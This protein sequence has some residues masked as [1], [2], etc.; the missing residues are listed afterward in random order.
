[1]PREHHYFT[2]IL[3]SGLRGTL[4]VGVT[5]DLM[6][7]VEEHR[8]GKGGAFTRRY[9]IH[10]LVW[11]EQYQEVAMAIEREK[12]VKKWRRDWKINLIERD[13]PYWYDL[14]SQLGS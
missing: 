1:M 10:R 5:N 12:N 13:N 9:G 7:R 2:C 11:Y 6:R 3:A 14:S 4:Y 8:T